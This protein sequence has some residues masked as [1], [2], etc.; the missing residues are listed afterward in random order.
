MPVFTF[1]IGVLLSGLVAGWSCYIV[2]KRYIDQIRY[3]TFVSDLM[4]DDLDT[5]TLRLSVDFWFKPF[6]ARK[7]NKTINLFLRKLG[8]QV[9]GTYE[10]GCSPYVMGQALGKLSRYNKKCQIRAIEYCTALSR[11]SNH[12][13]YVMSLMI[14]NPSISKRQFIGLTRE[15]SDEPRRQLIHFLSSDE[16]CRKLLN[17]L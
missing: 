10:V 1:L 15:I 7:D 5:F 8:K 16:Q 6:I 4:K 13:D 2:C 11:K 14:E 3:L 17:L 9:Y 12:A